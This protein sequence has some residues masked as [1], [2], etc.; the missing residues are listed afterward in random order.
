MENPNELFGQSNIKKKKTQN[1]GKIRKI[2]NLVCFYKWEIINILF[3]NAM[4]KNNPTRTHFNPGFNG[5]LVL[6]SR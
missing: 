2:N 6:I 1:I 4:K 3:K 5:G